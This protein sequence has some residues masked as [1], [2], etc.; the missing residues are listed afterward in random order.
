MTPH[1][2]ASLVKPS[3]RQ[4]NWQKTEFYGFINFGLPTVVN[5][6]WTD[7]N[8]SPANLVPDEFSAAEWVSLFKD[9][10]FKGMVLNVKHHDG[11]CL[12]NSEY[13]NYCMRS[14]IN[15]E[16]E[17]KDIVKML[18]EE[19][20]KQGM[21]FGIAISPL[22]RNSKL[23]GKGDDYDAYFKALL[24]EVLTNYGDIFYVRFDGANEP[25]K[26]DE[27]QEYD[28]E[29]YYNVV[30]ECQPNAVIA[31]VGPDVR[32]YGNEWGVI[33]ENEWSVIPERYSIYNALEASK[34]PKKRR[35]FKKDEEYELDLGSRK[36]IKKDS[37]FIWYPCEVSVSI[38]DRW[39]YHKDDEYTAKTKDRLQKLYLQ[40]VG[41][42]CALMLG[43]PPMKNG[44]FA[45]MDSQILKAFGVDLKRTYSYKVSKIGEMTAT[46]NLSAEYDAGNLLL[47]DES[48]TWKPS[49]EDSQ[50]ELTITL[51][52]KD[53]FDKVVMMENIANGQHI[54]GYEIYVDEGN[55]EFKKIGFGQAVGYK[56]IHKI[57][58]IEAK[59]I[60]IKITSYRGNL[61]M[62]S[63]TL[64]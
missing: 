26:E 40:S 11:F 30:R 22:D 41:A 31:L 24:R 35:F 10:G 55:G 8:V 33:R 20:A 34:K 62:Q 21:K 46:S 27:K 9:A 44:K 23:F 6:E 7:G 50:P 39:F 37:E 29:G 49:E 15:W 56:R 16:A 59:R 45:E 28:W 63:V 17:E 36:A 38:R 61:E 25:N 57:T 48:K 47:D 3:E 42:N 64:Y 14:C 12:W 4:I 19:C 5:T 32:W 2:I 1:E 52:Q 53:M 54:E 13:T 43:V 18:S 58:P 60:K 51:S